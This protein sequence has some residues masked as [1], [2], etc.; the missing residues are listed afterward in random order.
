M[1]SYLMIMSKAGFGIGCSLT[2]AEVH[3]ALEWRFCCSLCVVSY[4]RVS[5][6][7]LSHSL[8]GCYSPWNAHSDRC[9]CIWVGL[10]KLLPGAKEGVFRT[11]SEQIKNSV[12]FPGNGTSPHL[13]YESMISLCSMAYF[14]ILCQ[15]A[16][17]RHSLFLERRGRSESTICFGE[18]AKPY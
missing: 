1:A 7:S 17:F 8:S 2:F 4:R 11:L 5:L 3:S 14:N 18:T 15:K 6:G 12:F 10:R 16:E 9:I 13:S